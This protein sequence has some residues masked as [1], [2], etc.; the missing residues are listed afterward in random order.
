MS[1]L[2][3][4]LVAGETLLYRT[5][6]HAYELCKETADLVLYGLPF[7]LLGIA[8]ATITSNP[9][10]IVLSLPALWWVKEWGEEVIRWR[11]EEYGCTSNNRYL[12]VWFRLERWEYNAVAVPINAI[13]T[14]EHSSNLIENKLGFERVTI[15]TANDHAN[16]KGNRLPLGLYRTLNEI[17]SGGK[18]PNAPITG[19]TGEAISI[20]READRL[21]RDGFLEE[22]R[23]RAIQQEVGRRLEQALGMI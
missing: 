2:D 5:T 21:R 16:I 20:S 12:K 9:R 7:I 1:K 15:M 3:D 17:K 18:S 23:H 14:L 11:Y 4:E 8:V 10:L 6:R 22:E 13:I 19:E